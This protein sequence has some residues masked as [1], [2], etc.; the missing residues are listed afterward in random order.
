MRLAHRLRLH[1]SASTLLRI[2]RQR[3]SPPAP[4]P[5][6]IGVA[7]WAWRKGWRYGTVIVDLKRRQP[8]VLLPD[9]RAATL[10]ASL[11][12]SKPSRA[13]ETSKPDDLW[14]IGASK[15][16]RLRPL[17]AVRPMKNCSLTR[18]GLL[19]RAEPEWEPMIPRLRAPL[20]KCNEKAADSV[21]SAAFCK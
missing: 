16:V 5:T 2:V 1:T 4:D 15:S 19:S 6:L 7:D 9:R 18:C 20:P 12:S 14:R 13:S 21:E 11:A 10:A 8:V 3:A 17:Q